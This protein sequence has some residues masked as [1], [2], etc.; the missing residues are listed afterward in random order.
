[1]IFLKIYAP[2]FKKLLEEAETF[3]SIC[4]YGVEIEQELQTIQKKSI[5]IYKSYVALTW[6]TITTTNVTPW[7]FNSSELAMNWHLFCNGETTSCHVPYALAQLF[8]NV[9]AANISLAFEGIFLTL[10]VSAYR[11][12]E[13][14]K[15]VLGQI[16][17]SDDNDDERS[18]LKTLASIIEYHN[19]IL[20]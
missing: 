18:N 20:K 19:K 1:M 5:K 3:W 9:L 11:E 16:P 15:L 14:I 17:L 2:L 12:I 4:K 8:H 10:I 6:W 7:L 13:V